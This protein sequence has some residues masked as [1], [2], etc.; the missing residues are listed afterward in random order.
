[1]CPTDYS[2]DIAAYALIAEKLGCSRYTLREW[3]I[4]ARSNVRKRLG[5]SIGN[6][7]YRQP[8]PGL[9]TDEDMNGLCSN[10]RFVFVGVQDPRAHRKYTRLLSTDAPVLADLFEPRLVLR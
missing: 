1:M 9:L 2:S 6:G 5:Q 10:L 4:P 7:S 8:H 3:G